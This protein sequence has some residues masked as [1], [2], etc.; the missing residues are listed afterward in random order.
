MLGVADEIACA[1]ELEAAVL[2]CV[3]SL[4]HLTVAKGLYAVG[5]EIIRIGLILGDIA[6]ITDGEEGLVEIYLYGIAD[7]GAYPM[8]SALYLEV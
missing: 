6:R 3:E 7:I 4:F 2:A 8:D 1:N 5:I